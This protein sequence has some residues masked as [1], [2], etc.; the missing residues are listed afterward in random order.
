MDLSAA[1]FGSIHS[2]NLFFLDSFILPL[3]SFR[4]LQKVSCTELF[5]LLSLLLLPVESSVNIE[6][7]REGRVFHIC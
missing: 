2:G 4:P 1:M 6:D 7:S 5:W 3:Q